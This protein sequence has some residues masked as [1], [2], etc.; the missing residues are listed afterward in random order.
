MTTNPRD[1]DENLQGQFLKPLS[2]PAVKIPDAPP[3]PVIVS[4]VAGQSRAGTV[5]SCPPTPALS[6]SLSVGVKDR[7]GYFGGKPS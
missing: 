5:I 4:L 6:P 7:A 2:L 3:V 1:I